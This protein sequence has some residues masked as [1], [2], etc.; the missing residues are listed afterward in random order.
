M[1]MACGDGT[2]TSLLAARVGDSGSVVA[3][4]INPAYLDLAREAVDRAGQSARVDFLRGSIEHLPVEPDRF[5]A[6]WC[7]QSLFSLP[8]PVSALAALR[9]VV[10][11]GGWVAVLENDTLHQVVLPWPV[12]VEL[13]V[14]AAELAE[15]ADKTQEPRKYY[16][17]RRMGAIFHEAGLEPSDVRTDSHD[18]QA[19]LDP[20]ARAFLALYIADLRERV[21]PRL[22][23]RDR[24]D[25]ERLAD[26]YS[27]AYLLDEPYLTYTVLDHLALGRVPAA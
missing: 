18:R 13:A 11:P 21:S 17:A 24:G 12:E 25:F 14:R 5:D 4:D 20:D 10:R 2:Y 7:A 8:E 6:A 19:P 26:P 16:A 3:C 15:L 9:C 27:S 23:P 1:D 22:S